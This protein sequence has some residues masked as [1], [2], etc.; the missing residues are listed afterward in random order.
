MSDK[1]HYEQELMKEIKGRREGKQE[2]K[3]ERARQ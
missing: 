2:R 1:R 3:T